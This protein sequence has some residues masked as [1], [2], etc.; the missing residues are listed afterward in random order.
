MKETMRCAKKNYG[1]LRIFAALRVIFYPKRILGQM[2]EPPVNGGVICRVVDTTV[3]RRNVRK[4]K[5]FLIAILVL[6]ASWGR[7]RSVHASKMFAR[8]E[9]LGA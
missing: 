7:G 4:L 2:L 5:I 3:R 6:T 1:N 8:S 9:R